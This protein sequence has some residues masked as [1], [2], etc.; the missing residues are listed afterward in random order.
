MGR[1]G[2]PS[3]QPGSGSRRRPRPPPPVQPSGRHRPIGSKVLSRSFSLPRRGPVDQP[4]CARNHPRWN[5]V[6]FGPRDGVSLAL[7]RRQDDHRLCRLE[8]IER[9]RHSL[10][11]RLW[12]VLDADHKARSLQGG[13]AGEQRCG[14]PVLPHSQDHDVQR[15]DRFD[16]L[17]VQLGALMRPQ[18]GGHAV[19]GGRSDAIEQRL[20]GHPVVALGMAGA[21]APLVAEQ[22]AHAAPFDL[23]RRQ[24]LVAPFRRG[25][26]GQD[27]GPCPFPQSLGDSRRA[28]CRD[29][30]RRLEDCE[31]A[32]F[33]RGHTDTLIM[34]APWTRGEASA[35]GSVFEDRVW[36]LLTEQSRGH[37][38][39]FRPL[40]DRGVDALLHRLSDGAYIPVQAKARSSLIAGEV[41]LVVAAESVGDDL[42]VIV[43]GEIIDGGLGPTFLVVPTP[44]F[45]RLALLTSADGEP[46]YSMSFSAK[47]GTRSRWLPWL[48]SSDRL[49]ERFGVP[50]GLSTL[51]EELPRLQRS[52][53]GFLGEAEVI[54]QLAEAELLNLFR[55]F[56]DLETVELAVRNVIN[57]HVVGLQIKTVRVDAVYP[58]RPVDIYMS[59]FRPA[60]TTY[61]TVVAW[62]P[63]KRSF[64]DQCLVIPSEEL[65]LFATP[66]GSHYKFEFNPDPVKQ[67][68]LDKYRR[69]LTDLC[70][71]ID[72]LL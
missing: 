67:H 27:E 23:H 48:A 45:R 39:V 18:L 68:H 60:P 26:A 9:Q 5:L 11:W 65:L 12:R 42:V 56:P 17:R 66:D 4:S 59:S 25:A 46:E 72:S 13:M 43:G 41:Q 52:P 70:S 10:R 40:L 19:D 7:A 16:H 29:V 3:R 36:A 63:E 2:R 69:H 6:P 22:D 58:N 1:N 24:Q 31:A 15:R 47:P 37:L 38:H 30:L 35:S 34:E 33:G 55:P 20:A 54:R 53:L 44:D 64:H 8:G 51:A 21:D 28:C 57:G 62:I 32:R 14:V 61:F 49:A 50:L 71:E